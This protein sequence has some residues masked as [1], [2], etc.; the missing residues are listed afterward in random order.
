MPQGGQLTCGPSAGDVMHDG[1]P[2]L[3]LRAGLSQ[4]L[5]LCQGEFDGSV[6]MH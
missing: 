2:D 1:Q 4:F 5:G 3:I 6:T